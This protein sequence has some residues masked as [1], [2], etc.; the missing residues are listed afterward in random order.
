MTV[1][2]PRTVVEDEDVAGDQVA[3]PADYFTWF[4]HA[5]SPTQTDTDQ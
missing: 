3:V 5:R 1:Q 4:T 2:H